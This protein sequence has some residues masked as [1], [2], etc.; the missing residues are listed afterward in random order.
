MGG[1]GND[2]VKNTY[3]IQILFA[4][5][6]KW[7]K[8]GKFCSA[9]SIKVLLYSLPLQILVLMF[10]LSV[11]LSIVFYLLFSLSA[12]QGQPFSHFVSLAFFFSPL[13]KLF[14]ISPLYCTQFLRHNSDKSYLCLVHFR[15]LAPAWTI[16]S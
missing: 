10:S 7:A 13:T 12:I 8:L 3:E 2:A 15:S 16:S 11:F 9:F 4:G 5:Y 6:Q 1:G 14:F